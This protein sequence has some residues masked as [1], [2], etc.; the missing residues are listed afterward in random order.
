MWLLTTMG[1]ASPFWATFQQVKAAGGSVRKGAHGVPVVFW[2]V[3]DHTDPETGAAD[4]RFVL[5]QYTVFNAT[6]V[7]GVAIPWSR[8]L[9]RFGKRP[10]LMKRSASS[11]SI[12]SNPRITARLNR[13]L[14]PDLRRRNRR[15]R[16]R[17]GQ[18]KSAYSE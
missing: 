14:E 1:Y 9:A 16:C 13:A 6:Q 12:P 2:R 15:R 7:D 18:V 3:Y 10:S 5:R 8:S 17:N 11:G 4:K